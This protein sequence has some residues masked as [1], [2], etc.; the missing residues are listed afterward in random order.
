MVEELAESLPF[1][2]VEFC[3]I[4][5]NGGARVSEAGDEFLDEGGLSSG[6]ACGLGVGTIEQ[7]LDE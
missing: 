2:H 3:D 6:M 7:G 1:S 4:V 5:A